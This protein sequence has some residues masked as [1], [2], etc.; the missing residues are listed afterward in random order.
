MECARL[1]GVG[2]IASGGGESGESCFETRSPSPQPSPQERG[3]IGRRS[4]LTIE[5][6]GGWPRRRFWGGWSVFRGKAEDAGQRVRCAWNGMRIACRKKLQ[7]GPKK[8]GKLK[9]LSAY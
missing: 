4:S 1:A 7:N 6:V 8:T 5:S 9:T 3:R 2:G